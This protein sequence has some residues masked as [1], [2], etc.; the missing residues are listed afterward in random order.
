DNSFAWGIND[1]GQIAGFS[2][3]ATN[4]ARAFL[5]TPGTGLQ[6]L[7]TFPGGRTSSASAVNR[8]G[9]VVGFSSGFL[10]SGHAALWS[11][12]EI[13]DLGSLPGYPSSEAVGINALSVI[14]GTA[15]ASGGA[16]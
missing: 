8:L 5:Y 1:A 9:Q 3:N 7:G 11:G 15:T 12:G 2:R 14:A 10:F 6:D 13:R 16:T 4:D